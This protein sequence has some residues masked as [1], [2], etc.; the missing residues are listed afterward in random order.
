MIQPALVQ[1][2]INAALSSDWNIAIELNEQILALYPGDLD[3]LN[4]LARA[5]LETGDYG[6]SKKIYKEVLAIDPYNV[7]ALKN[8]KRFQLIK[9]SSGDTVSKSPKSNGSTLTTFIEEP[10]RTKVVQLL[11]PAE[12]QTLF[13]LHCGEC[14]DLVPKQRGVQIQVGDTYIGR[15]ADDLGHHLHNLMASG[16]TYEAYIKQIAQ[17]DVFIFIREVQRAEQ[18]AMRPTF[19]VTADSYITPSPTN[20]DSDGLDSAD[21]SDDDVDESE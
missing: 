4:R 10:G 20:G 16:N 2:A 13:M 18:F 21:T 5:Y 8:L 12:P 19:S 3:S 1:R 7:I 15:L 6:R 17:N 14:V 9:M 11:R